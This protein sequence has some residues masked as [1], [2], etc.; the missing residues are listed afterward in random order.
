MS[1]ITQL[2]E[3]E[4]PREKCLRFGADSLSDEE[5]LAIVIGSGYQGKNAKDIAYELIS[6]SG[7]L[8]SLSKQSYK[9]FLS[10]KG[11]SK[12]KALTLVAI[13]E[14]S[15]RMSI[16]NTEENL[17]DITSEYLYQKYKEYLKDTS[18][19]CLVIICLN[20]YKKIIHEELLFKGTE[21]KVN[22]SIKDICRVILDFNSS[23]FYLLHN[24]PSGISYP[25]KEDIIFTENLIIQTDNLSIPLVDHLII[26]RN[27]YYSLK[28]RICKNSEF[29]C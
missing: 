24:H 12:V 11:I 4:R 8:T 23:S 6:Q 2:P 28:N 16:K 25:S 27:D 1:K 3:L 15:K 17:A 10:H 7:G 21:S 22:I 26:G 13:V 19:E 20:R 14:L 9:T 18:Q 29:Y 5:L